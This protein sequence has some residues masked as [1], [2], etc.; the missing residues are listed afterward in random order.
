M[1]PFLS[2]REMLNEDAK[3]GQD[4]KM[5]FSKAVLFTILYLEKQ[6]PDSIS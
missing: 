6:K 3:L 4:V 1:E 2:E 5:K